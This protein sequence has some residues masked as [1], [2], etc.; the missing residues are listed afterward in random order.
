MISQ[1]FGNEKRARYYGLRVGDIVS[2]KG[3]DGKQ[4]IKGV[5]E[6]IDYGVDN[7]CVLIKSNDG[8]TSEWVAEWC[9]II[10]KVEDR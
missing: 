8:T 1:F 6:V 5:A 10:T 4:W 3:L 7:N 9:E 2:P